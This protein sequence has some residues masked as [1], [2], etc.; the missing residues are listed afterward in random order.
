[1]A[2]ADFENY[3]KSD[4]GDLHFKTGAGAQFNDKS[5]GP[6]DPYGDVEKKEK[7]AIDMNAGE[8]FNKKDYTKIEVMGSSPTN[9]ASA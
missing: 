7:D 3:G 1:M 8:A 2:K 9:R 5:G 4:A 6:I